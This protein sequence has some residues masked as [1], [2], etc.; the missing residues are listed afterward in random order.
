MIRKKYVTWRSLEKGQTV[1]SWKIGN[2]TRMARSTVKE[3]NAAFVTLL[4]FGTTEEQ[5]P[6]EGTMF[7]V[8][9]TEQE[10]RQRY[11]KQAEELMAAIQTTLPRYAIGY[12]EMWNSWITYDPYEMAALCQKDKIRIIGHCKDIT[13]K[14]NLF[15]NTVQDIG[16]CAEYEDGEKIWCHASM[17]ALQDMLK[18]WE[19]RQA[20]LVNEAQSN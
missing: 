16:I 14:H 11:Q 8:D 9:M 12:H 3:K 17:D 15:D 20:R 5:I 18:L 19:K 13:P 7:E 1:H 2:G 4:I 6:S 10:F